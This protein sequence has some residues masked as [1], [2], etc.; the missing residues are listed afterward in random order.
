[1]SLNFFVKDKRM[2]WIILST[3]LI[4]LSG[5]DTNTFC[6]LR[7]K[8]LEDKKNRF[9]T[10]A[11]LMES[12]TLRWKQIPFPITITSLPLS[13]M[14]AVLLFRIFLIFI[15]PLNEKNSSQKIYKSYNLM[16]TS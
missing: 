15:I 16:K 5:K 3:I 8:S 1:M 4:S 10:N 6:R 12:P 9:S 11:L 2:F 7:F 14:T 13:S